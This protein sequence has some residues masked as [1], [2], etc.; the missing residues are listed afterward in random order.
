MAF[1]IKIRVGSTVL[2]AELNDSETA[3]Q[4]ASEL[5]IEEGSFNTWGDE[6]Y[7]SIPVTAD[8]ENAVETVDLGDLGYWPPGKAFCIFFGKTP[9]SEGDEI[10]PASPVNPIGR[11]IGDTTVLKTVSSG[12]GIIIEVA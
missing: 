10:R 8:P 12:E 5:P 3:R 6:I 4:I 7:F 1:P 11:V 9:A 2:D